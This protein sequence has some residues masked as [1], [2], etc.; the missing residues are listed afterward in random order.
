[1]TSPDSTA[2]PWITRGFRSWKSGRQAKREATWKARAWTV[3]CFADLPESV[4]VNW[5]HHL[6]REKVTRRATKVVESTTL[7][8]SAA[9]PVMASFGIRAAVLGAT[10]AIVAVLTGISTR[11]QYRESWLRHNRVLLAI[12][13]EIV[14]YAYGWPP[15]ETRDS[16]GGSGDQKFRAGR[17]AVNVETLV[18][19]D[20]DRWAE[21]ELHRAGTRDEGTGTT[22]DG[23]DPR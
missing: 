23:V 7:L 10:G 11:Y 21:R 8:L 18:R 2:A 6:D 16:S 22:H 5:K 12:Q 15:Y 3:P 17:L 13:G 9:I 1:M 20:A 4:R 19:T 14:R